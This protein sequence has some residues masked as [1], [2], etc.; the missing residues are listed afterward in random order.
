MENKYPSLSFSLYLHYFG[1]Q[2]EII[3]E[4]GMEYLYNEIQTDIFELCTG[5]N[6]C[7]EIVEKLAVVYNA[8]SKM[9]DELKISV[10]NFIK[11]QVNKNI[12]VLK[13]VQESMN[14]IYGE[15]GKFYP[16]A[17]SIEVTNKCNFS[18]PHCYKSALHTGKNIDPKVI[19]YIINNFAGKTRQI[20]LTGG[21]PFL[22]SNISEYIEKLADYFEIRIPTNG[23]L[24]WH[25]D[26]TTLSKIGFV[27]ISLYG[28]NEKEYF[29]FT[30][31]E[32]AFNNLKISIS[33]LNECN[34]SNILTVILSKK[35]INRIEEYIITGIKLGAQRIKFGV[36]TAIG[37][38]EEKA[39]EGIFSL[40]DEE[41]RF[42]YRQMRLLKTKYRNEISV[43]IWSHRS[44]ETIKPLFAGEVFNNMPPCGAGYLSYVISQNGR[45]RPCELLPESYFDLGDY[46][47]LENYI[48]GNF[49]T[50][51]NQVFSTYNS[52]KKQEMNG[53]E[54]ICKPIM[55]LFKN[56]N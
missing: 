54:N 20:Q 13:D 47:Q 38:A 41:M 34:V 17:L 18:C 7:S 53:I 36:P 40:S 6:T 16:L 14:N 52:N 15:R 10:M 25:V 37:R 29:Q 51:Y 30:G 24:L 55:T 56:I 8:N 26:K 12:L 31:N 48:N 33:K 45:L 23:S 49:F 21:E 39:N 11:T 44:Q 2:S 35:N 27:Q 43:G 42:A 50:N 32:N 1:K 5:L 22:N 3:D 19:D 28:C 46:M 4:N 9:F